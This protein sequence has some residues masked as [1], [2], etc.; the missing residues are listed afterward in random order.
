MTDPGGSSPAS[1]SDAAVAPLLV[2]LLN[3]ASG[4]IAAGSDRA[5]A[6]VHDNFDPGTEGFVNFLPGGDWRTVADTAAALRRGGFQ[7][8]PHI[9]ARSLPD[10]A[11][12]TDFV[13]R[14]RE[15][16]AVDRVLVI[17]GDSPKA[18]GPF[19]SSLDVI[20]SGVLEASG[21]ASVGVAG[22]PEGHPVIAPN[23][24]LESL[25]TKA[26]ASTRAGL[27]LFIVTQFTFEGAPVL[28]W[29]RAIR[30]AGVAAPVQIGLAG[31]ATIATLVRFGMRCGIGNSLRAL[32]ARPN[33]VGRLL[34]KAGPEDVIA[35]LGNGLPGMPGHGV[36]GLHFFPFGGVA[37]TGEFIA[38]TLARLYQDIAPAEAAT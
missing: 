10:R 26:E 22:H 6:A 37:E 30:A 1:A 34:G 4:E 16:A 3:H 2:E 38:R 32:R 35:E 31:P 21:I 18:A 7:P 28:T 36:V 27:D 5:L 8:V 17:A 9:A 24:L 23:V 11:A 14:L 29:L 19:A 13:K 20:A 12:L 33:T 15:D 25:R